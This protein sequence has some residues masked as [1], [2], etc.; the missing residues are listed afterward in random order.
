MCIFLVCFHFS[1]ILQLRQCIFPFIYF[2]RNARKIGH[3][4]NYRPF[5]TFLPKSSVDLHRHLC[6]NGSRFCI[7]KVQRAGIRLL[8]YMEKRFSK[9][10]K[11]GLAKKIIVYSSVLVIYYISRYLDIRRYQFL[12]DGAIYMYTYTQFPAF[13]T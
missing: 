8:L 10:K 7:H 6:S 3:L 11:C 12:T 2:V 5:H 1:V 9:K 13:G 4:G